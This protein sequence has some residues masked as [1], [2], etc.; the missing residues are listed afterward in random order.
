VVFRRDSKV[1]A[2]QRQIS[3]LRHQLGGEPEEFPLRDVESPRALRDE[4]PYRFE[5]P[6]L[7][8]VAAVAP[9]AGFSARDYSAPVAVD[10]A[11]GF[12]RLES[13]L[14]AVPAVD[15]LTSV[16]SHTT[17]WSGNLESSGSLHV[18]G[19]VEGSLAAKDAIFVAEEAE[20]DAVVSAATVTVAGRVRGSIYCA[21]RCEVLPRGRVAGD[22]R[23]PVLVVHEG[24]IIAGEIAM[25]PASD[26]K[27][28]AVAGARVARGG[29]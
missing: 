4:N 9:A 15:S 11:A 23:A 5:L 3:A 7:E 10:H 17:A 12:D 18:H 26:A 13:E 8:P 27:A 21:E 24:A 16:I 29:D 28:A 25:A 1:D 14:P 2:F 19:R 22:V 6:A 20:V